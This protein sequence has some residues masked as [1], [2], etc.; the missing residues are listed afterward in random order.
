MAP[1]ADT[2][3]QL[4]QAAGRLRAH[5]DRKD[6]ELA[7]VSGAQAGALLAIAAS[8]GATQRALAAALGQR[9]SAVATMV[10]RLMAAGLVRRTARAGDP[11]SW[12]LYLTARGRRAL[13]AVTLQRQ[14]MS[15]L[16]S[17]ALTDEE[18]ATLSVLL[19]RLVALPLEPRRPG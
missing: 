10:V 5:L 4:Q 2:Y 1:R 16:I 8:P 12:A 9:E 13:Q 15:R 11:R 3:Q 18:A 19:G 14:D 7:G 17:L 6:L